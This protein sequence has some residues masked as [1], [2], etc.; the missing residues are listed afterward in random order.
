[1]KAAELDRYLEESRGLERDYLE[2]MFAAV[3]ARD[4]SVEGF[5]R[6]TLELR[7]AELQSLRETLLA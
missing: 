5:L 3:E 1:M 2:A 4:G 7:A 6:R